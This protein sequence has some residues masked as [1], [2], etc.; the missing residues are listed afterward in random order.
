MGFERVEAGYGSYQD[1][2]ILSVYSSGVVRFNSVATRQW[3]EDV[4]SVTFYI[5]EEET[6]I[7]IARGDGDYSLRTQ[8]DR[9]GAEA[10]GMQALKRLGVD[11]DEIGSS[12]QL[13]LEHDP[14]EGL[15]VAD[16]TPLY[17]EVSDDGR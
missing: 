3:L 6:R 1:T 9:V 14:A 12:V 13:E 17:E 15:L 7:G 16:A 8:D 2:P 5:D 10:Y 4:D 11:P